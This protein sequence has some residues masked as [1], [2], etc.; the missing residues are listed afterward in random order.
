MGQRQSEEPHLPQEKLGTIVDSGALGWNLSLPL[1][2]TYG[3]HK[4]AVARV[5]GMPHHAQVLT[6]CLQR[7]YIWFKKGL[8]RCS[9]KRTEVL[10]LFFKYTFP[11]SDCLKIGIPSHWDIF[12]CLGVLSSGQLSKLHQFFFTCVVI[13]L[14]LP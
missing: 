1:W 2:D 11:F 14:L 10:F 9:P 6:H 13:T 4:G 8:K 3:T 5:R 7:K 12:A